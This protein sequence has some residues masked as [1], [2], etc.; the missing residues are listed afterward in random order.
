MDRGARAPWCPSPPNVL[1]VPVG[2]SSDQRPYRARGPRRVPACV[3]A[4]RRATAS[5]QNCLTYGMTS[6]LFVMLMVFP[7]AA[8][9]ALTFPATVISL[10]TLA[11]TAALFFWIG[12][13]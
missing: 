3:P 9:V 8:A 2:L 5:K 11:A 4:Q 1:G 7:I 12:E 6:S 10:T 13:D